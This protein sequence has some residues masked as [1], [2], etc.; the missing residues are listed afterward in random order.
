MTLSATTTRHRNRCAAFGVS[1]LTPVTIIGVCALTA[2]AAQANPPARNDPIGRIDSA[3]AARGGQ[4]RLQGWAADPDTGRNAA[5]AALVDGA[6]LAVVRTSV[7]RPKITT[8]HHTGPTPGFDLTVSVPTSG[9]H[10]VCVAATNM[11][12]GLTRVLGCVATPLGST[13]TGTQLAAHS[14]YGV[15]STATARTSRFRVTGWAGEPDFRVGRIVTMLYLD[16]ALAIT[17]RTHVASA[18]QRRAGA[19]KR[20]AFDISVP[21]AAG[22]HTGCV[23]A[24]NTGLGWNRLLGCRAADTRGPAGHG[25]VAVPK[26]NKK[27][28]REAKKHIGQRY[29]WGAEGPRTFDCSGLVMYSYHKAGYPTPRI[30]ADQFAAARVI[31]AARAVRGD[32]VFYH[33]ST[34]YVYHVGIYLSPLNTVAAIDEQQG[35]APQHIWDPSSAAYGSFTHT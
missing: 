11:G 32:L 13:L 5:V 1:L 14:P 8:R 16:G 2:P 12:P 31:P 28:V 9:V 18:A 23:W 7:V 6:K 33:D 22:S 3:T 34:G 21:V 24:V 10:T 29:V 20:G 15:L 27:V 19:G 17:A 4:I 25:A 30:A 26:I 35:V